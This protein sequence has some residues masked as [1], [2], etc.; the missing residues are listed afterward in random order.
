L[1]FKEIFVMVLI[2]GIFSVA[3]FSFAINLQNENDVQNGISSDSRVAK[4]FGNLSKQ[5]NESSSQADS[6]KIGL[7]EEENNPTIFTSMGFV[8]KS[9]LT[10][11]NTFMSMGLNIFTYLFVFAG[12]LLNIN[13]IITGAFMAIISGVI[14]LAI[15]SVVRAGR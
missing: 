11:G 13:P 4:V 9:T 12:S 2:I 5:L 3:L 7:I 1:E 6:A 14:V 8:F 15:W 10:A